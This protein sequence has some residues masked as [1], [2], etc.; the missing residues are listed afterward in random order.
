VLSILSE[1]E[2]KDVI[3]SYRQRLTST[4]P[5]VQLEAAKLWERVGRGDGDL[6]AQQR[7]GFFWRGRFRAGVRPYRNHYFTH[8]GFLDSD[9]QLLR[10]VPLIRHIPAVII[11]GRY[12]M[13]CQVQNAWDLRRLGRRRS[14]ILLRGP[15]TH[16]MSPASCTS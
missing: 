12:D 15:D 14:C 4:D 5:Q 13:A 1:E 7:V 10:N 16:S 2:R 9:D 6:A 3:A 11:H 8:L